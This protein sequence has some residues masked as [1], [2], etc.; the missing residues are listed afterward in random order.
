MATE[1]P[2]LHGAFP[3]GEGDELSDSGRRP[4][5]FDVLGPDKVTSILP[6]GV[7]LV[8]H[9][10]PSSM[11]VK[12]QKVIERIQTKGGWVEQHFGDGAQT[13][14]FNNATGGFMRLYA[15]MSNITSPAETQGTR[16]E[17]LA[18]DSYLDLLAM[19]HNNGSVYD[20]AD[21][22]A[23]QGTIKITFDEGVYLGQWTSF[24]MSEEASGPYQFQLTA[25]FE[26]QTEVQVW[27]STISLGGGV[28][29][30][31]LRFE[32]PISTA[33]PPI[34]DFPPEITF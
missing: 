30:G 6:E 14:D 32:D 17:T 8:L 10:N 4:V 27:R 18:Y 16:R 22:V 31:D 7:R 11:S 9:V 3:A 28:G 12:Y 33:Q 24:T 2:L 26:V 13:I 21:Q 25:G 20:D 1:Q 5:I 34:G 23:L 19:F 15:G 29:N